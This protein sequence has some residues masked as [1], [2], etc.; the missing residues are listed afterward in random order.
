MKNKNQLEWKSPPSLPAL[1]SDDVHLWRV[2]LRIASNQVQQFQGLLASDEMSRM[3]RF[4]FSSD[5]DCYIIVRGILR[6]LL[7]IYLQIPPRQI[8]FHYSERG[9]PILA[10]GQANLF[11]NFNV[12]HSHEQALLAFT[13]NRAI[14][15]DLEY[16]RPDI[17]REH[18]A[19]RFFSPQETNTLRMLPDS[20]QPVA[21]FNCWTRKEAFI[22]ATGE[23]L[24]RPL[25]Q[26]SVSLIPGEPARLLNIQPE[27]SESFAWLLQ[28]LDVGSKYA[29]ALAVQ[30]PVNQIFCWEYTETSFVQ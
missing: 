6:V 4:R 19:E 30:H 13:Y 7:G 2:S 20:L 15:V 26:F 29:A 24:S 5:R 16:I 28:E 22:K 23:G 12:S 27:S 3:K 25:D 9:K 10:A 21:F 11:L 17:V 8:K 14:G 18:V 1:G